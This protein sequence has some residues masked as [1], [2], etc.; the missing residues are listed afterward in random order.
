MN[1][2]K[3]KLMNGIKLRKAKENKNATPKAPSTKIIGG[4]HAWQACCHSVAAAV[5]EIAAAGEC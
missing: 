4:F 3:Q 2:F 1:A 5:T